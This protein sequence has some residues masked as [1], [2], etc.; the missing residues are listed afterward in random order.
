MTP[1]GSQTSPTHTALIANARMYSV[2][3]AVGAL[4]R[5][6]LELIAQR[7]SLAIAIIEH[8]EPQPISELWRRDDKGAVFM[9][10]LPYARSEPRPVLIAAPVPA[11]AAFGGEPVYWSELVV[12]ADGS[13]HTLEDTFGGTLAFTSPESQ[14]GCL[15]AMQHFMAADAGWPLY[16][17]L[18]APQVTPRG[19]VDAVIRGRADVAPVDAFALKL[20]QKYEPELT[21]QLRV[22]AR[23]VHTPIPPLVASSAGLESL[24]EAFLQV[25]ENPA[26]AS[27][28][29]D[30]LVERF[31]LPDPASY[32]V[33]RRRFEAASHFWREH[34]LASVMHP[35]FA[36]LTQ[37]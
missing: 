33:L 11:P 35:A 37:P 19:A 28:M 3:P 10:G 15:A 8:A 24:R 14:S 17:E 25:H 36:A 30:L 4:W 29:A 20:L 13:L 26:A 27:L 18:I 5:Q 7:T 16:R 23:T 22:V 31:V 32:D 2:N 9:C 1:A 34:P 6:L 21:S 12:R